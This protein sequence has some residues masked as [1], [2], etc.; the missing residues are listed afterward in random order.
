MSE[1][2]PKDLA[3][4]VQSALTAN[5][6]RAPA[7]AVLVSLFEVLYFAS[8]KTEEGQGISC[9]V[10][11]IK[12]TRPDPNR[13][14]RIVADR[15][16][17]FAFES[18]IP[19]SVRNLVKLSK[20]ADPWVSTIAVDQGSDGELAIWGLIDQSVHYST[21]VMNETES[22]GQMP[23]LFQAAIQ[24]TG[25]IGVYDGYTFL[26][27]LRQGVLVTRES[28]VLQHGPIRERLLPAISA[29]RNRVA[30]NVG[31]S[32]YEIRPHWDGSLE[33]SWISTLSR[34]LIGIRR[35]GHGGALLLTDE[36]GGLRVKY[37]LRYTRLSEA[38]VR[39][40]TLRVQHT[41]YSDTLMEEFIEKRFRT[42][43]TELHLD[44]SVT[45][46]ELED[47]NNEITGCVRF[48]S[49]LSRVDGLVWLK[50]DL[51]LQGFGVE[52]TSKKDPVSIFGASTATAKNL[53]EI[54]IDDFGTRHRSMMRHCAAYP[55]SVGFVVSQDGDVRAIARVGEQIVLWDN[56]RL[57][58]THNISTSRLRAYRVG[59]SSIK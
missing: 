31:K 45:A 59:R 41:N 29:F 46:S 37:P 22:W 17:H 33:H 8:L 9:R 54:D 28:G 38:L 42:V 55:D 3:S 35:Y 12:R 47:T 58:S 36:T 30:T 26:G 18:E 23:G 57:Y 27:S 24:G 4:H 52:I 11:F 2:Y 48:L 56:I 16:Q 53:K 49:L 43:P 13:P 39:Q 25:E 7:L 50:S 10:A 6:K 15:W 1:C 44:E 14:K 20:A 5:R 34:V 21:A 19:C 40:G 32:A 51:T